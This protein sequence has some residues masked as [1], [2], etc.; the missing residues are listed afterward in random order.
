MLSFSSL[1]KATSLLRYNGAFNRPLS[2]DFAGY[3]ENEK[4]HFCSSWNVARG[5]SGRSLPRVLGNLG[6]GDDETGRSS[7]PMDFVRGIVEEDE[8][9]F[10]GPSQFG[11]FPRYNV[12]HSSEFVH[13]KLMRNNTF[14]TVT[15]SKG[16]KRIGASSGCLPELKGGPKMSRYA[17]EATAEHVG[18]LARNMGLKSV[19]VRVKGFTYF[20]KKRQAIMSFREG[21]ANS[22]DQNPIVYIEDTTRRPHNGC[23]LP[24]K[25]RI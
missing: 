4:R 3:F 15:D 16:N 1:R 19:V 23:R 11:Q 12:E 17:A 18:R 8:K 2:A 24:K 9:R 21:F 25:R 6:Q 10:T 7:R 22:R 13:I 14:V 5:E 20:K